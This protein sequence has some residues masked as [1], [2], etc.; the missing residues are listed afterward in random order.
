MSSSDILLVERPVAGGRMLARQDGRV[1]LIAGAIPGERVRVRIER[2][3]KQVAWAEVTEVVEPSADRREPG[4]DPACGGALYAHIAYARQLEIKRDV[5]ADAFRR[6]G[7][8]DLPG[9]PVVAASPE[10]GYR[11]R[12]RLHVRHGRAGFF[13]EGSHLVCDAAAT[14]QL[15]EG[16]MPAVD[17]LVASLGDRASDCD[18]VVIAE[19]IQADE[20]VLH[21]LPHPQHRLDD[22][23]VS[24]ESLAGVT[25]V[26]AATVDGPVKV[27]GSPYVSDAIGPFDAA[28]GTRACWRRHAASFFQANRFLLESLVRYVVD[29]AEGE[30][31]LDLYSG[32]GLFAVALAA[33]GRTVVAVEGDPVS[34]A[35]LIA[36]ASQSASRLAVEQSAVEPFL[37]ATRIPQLGTLVLDPP[38]T[39]ATPEALDG[40]IAWRPPQVIYVSCDPPTLA[41]DASRLVR[42]G[43]EL[44][45]VDA[46]DL[47][48]NTPH[49]ETVAVFRQT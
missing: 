2:A 45:S 4:S 27:V 6:I 21:L 13:R 31:C 35:D 37:R 34:A 41:R 1:V 28:Q 48:P 11:L 7:K 23:Q 42:G 19:N 9:S 3:S 46:F 43:Y 12:A 25:G 22:V 17:S 38:R 39:G 10:T 44:L 33:A 16:A 5:I 24:L 15:H 49:V 30:R 20:R 47:F 29:R 8:M 18:G 32:V 36:N 40:L 26:T 14:G